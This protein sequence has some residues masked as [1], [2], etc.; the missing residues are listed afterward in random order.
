MQPVYFFDSGFPHTLHSKQN[1]SDERVT[2]QLM[3][4]KFWTMK[5]KFN[6]NTFKDKWKDSEK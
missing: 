4:T 6:I 1:E 2:L 5:C 3:M